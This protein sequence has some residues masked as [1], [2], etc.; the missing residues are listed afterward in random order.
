MDKLYWG[1]SKE[2]LEDCF[3][4]LKHCINDKYDLYIKKIRTVYP[5]YQEEMI[6]DV[7]KYFS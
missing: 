7:C 5:E 3:Y 4:C 6:Y 2:E 1:L